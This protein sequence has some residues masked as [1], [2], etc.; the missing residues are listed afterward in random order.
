MKCVF[1][2]G[3][4][5]QPEHSSD[6]FHHGGRC[7]GSLHLFC[8]NGCLLQVQCV[9]RQSAVYEHEA[10]ALYLC[11]SLSLCLCVSLCDM[12]A[13]CVCG[14]CALLYS[15]VYNCICIC[16]CGGRISNVILPATLSYHRILLYSHILLTVTSFPAVW[17]AFPRTLSYSPWKFFN[18][19]IDLH[20]TGSKM[21][22]AFRLIFHLVNST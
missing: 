14:P 21:Y 7:E 2:R 10:E 12:P 5:R 22:Q 13:P 1:R 20:N 8:T 19:A 11:V 3:Q 9:C 16:V 15:H 6:G 18:Y 4:H 17:N